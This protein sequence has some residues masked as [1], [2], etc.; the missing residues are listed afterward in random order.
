MERLSTKVVPECRWKVKL[1]SHK[2]DGAIRVYKVS[3]TSE[4]RAML[5]AIHKDKEKFPDKP[6]R[7]SDGEGSFEIKKSKFQNEV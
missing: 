2:H 3:A 6:W 5:K 7:L 1:I 4:Q